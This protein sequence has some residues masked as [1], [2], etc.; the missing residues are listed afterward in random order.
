MHLVA[1]MLFSAFYEEF[2]FRSSDNHDREK[3]IIMLKHI[4]IN[5]IRLNTSLLAKTNCK[6][7]LLYFT[8]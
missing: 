2:I 4:S 6:Q 7:L 3:M 1:V 8:V 5:K